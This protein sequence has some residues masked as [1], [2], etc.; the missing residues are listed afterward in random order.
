L[1][2]PYDL[3]NVLVRSRQ[4]RSGLVFKRTYR[5][6]ALLTLLLS[7]VWSA[8][9][10]AA[11]VQETGYITMS[12]GVKLR[13]AAVLPAADGRF[14][15]AMKYDGYCE[16]TNPITCNE[17]SG[18]TAQELLDGGYAVVGVQVRGTGCS[19]GQFDFRNPE[20]ATD[21]AAAVEFV[22][23]Q[24]WSNGHIGMFGDSFPG[25]MQPGVA[26]LR[27]KGLDAIA[28]WQI[29]DD[30]YRDV[31]YPGGLGNGEFGVFW[32]VYN[33]PF[34]SA[35]AASGGVQAGDPQCAES[36]AGQVAVNLGTNIFVAG[37][38]HP[39]FDSY[40]ASKT[41]GDAAAKIDVPTLGCTTWQDDEVGSRAGWTMFPKLDPARTWMVGSNGFH[42]QCVFSTAMTEELLRFFGR[43]VKGE[44]NGYEK[45][46]HTQ[47]WHDAT[48]AADAKP[49]WVTDGGSWPP[50]AD[51][52][53]LYLGQG[54]ALTAA[55]PAGGEAA[56]DY[57]SPTVSAGTE[58]GIA[59]GQQ[60]Q[61]W[62]TPGTP[63]GAQ[64][65]TTPK[66]GRDVDLFGPA[67]L[68]LWIKST[69]TDAG[70]QA[71][72][73]EVRPDGQEVYVNRGWLT[74]S[75]RKLDEHASTATMPVQT[76]LES[77]A[78]PLEPGTPTRVRVE[79]FPFEHIFRAGSRIRVTVDTPSQTGGWNFQP[80]ANG[81]VNSILHDDQ[82]PS[83][84]VLSTMRAPSVKEG[85]PA[86]D[87]VLNQ[88][89]RPDAFPDS[90]PPGQLTWPAEATPGSGPGS[91]P[92][93]ARDGKSGILSAMRA[94][95]CLSRRST[96]GPRNIGRVRLGYSRA[97]LLRIPVRA[98][99]R[100]GRS[101]RYCVTGAR[102]L[103]TAVFSSRSQRARVKLVVTTARG[104][105]N[106]GLRVGSKATR[107]SRAYP[108]RV[109]IGRGLY[110]ARQGSPRLFGLRRG[111]VRF[112]AV[113]G[114]AV[115]R[116]RSSLARLLRAAGL[117]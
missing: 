113:A 3:A 27:P 23:R 68:N 79:V 87:T 86:C 5:R 52:N 115:T 92:G 109:R 1:V 112:I 89:C 107:F 70:L 84:L 56:D 83:E 28:P 26:A 114:R 16:G 111:R 4:G 67:S 94:E 22:E 72:I 38:Q 60:G 98:P 49:G 97:R 6:V 48:D 99:R 10:Q 102:G 35:G 11:P 33:Q 61:L 55:P 20:E 71:T 34:A 31:A 116:D 106:R 50:K 43:F 30:A 59:F 54:A 101:L 29:V 88:P 13:Y 91:G 117:R 96:I 36:A 90:A 14:P 40:W 15:V 21:G 7:V 2:K 37:Q 64:A 65:Y 95:R 45:T 66:L 76:H 108:N 32:G 8:Q 18:K 58:N 73:T 80:V 9:A 78:E 12:D 105:G 85:Y 75:Q 53:R 17:G 74:A 93:Q 81:G 100:A 51:A 82:H 39:Y 42:G 62:K 41:I 63:S 77:D 24:P 69:G 19:Q 25:L 103:V 110:H 44:Q 57:V 46:P 47:I 104:H